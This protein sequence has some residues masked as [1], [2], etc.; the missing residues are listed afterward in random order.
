MER[1]ASRLQTATNRDLNE[2]INI[3]E[4]DGQAKAYQVKQIREVI[5]NNKLEIQEDD[6]S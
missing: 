6:E 5:I 2:I 3:Q 4:I 1:I